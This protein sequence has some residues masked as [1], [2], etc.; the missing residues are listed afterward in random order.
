M[1]FEWDEAKNIANQRKHNVSFDL[2]KEVFDDPLHRGVADRIECSEQRW[3]TMGMV[4][5]AVLLIVAHSWRE[6]ED[7]EVVRIISARRATRRER[8]NYENS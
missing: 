7:S 1:R 3:N 5:G 2:A 4:R 6:D 8:R